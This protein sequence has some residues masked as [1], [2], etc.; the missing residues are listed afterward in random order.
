[1]NAPARRAP[2]LKVMRSYQ[3]PVAGWY[4]R[5]PFYLAYMLREATCVFVGYYAMLLIC[6]LER[7]TAGAAAFTHFIQTIG[8]PGWVVLHLLTLAAMLYHAITWFAV[9]P[10][11]MPFVFVAGKRVADSTIVRAGAFAGVLGALL[12]LVFFWVTQP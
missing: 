5:N 3:R 1:M 2:P 11:T 10:K 4:R 7:L 6:A 8:R 9:M 12:V